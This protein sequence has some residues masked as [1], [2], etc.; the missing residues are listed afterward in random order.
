MAGR[1]RTSPRRAMNLGSAPLQPQQGDA[2]ALLCLAPTLGILAGFF[3]TYSCSFSMR[4]LWVES[5]RSGG[6]GANMVVGVCW[7]WRPWRHS[8]WHAVWQVP[9]AL[10]EAPTM[11]CCTLTTGIHP[12]VWGRKRLG[13]A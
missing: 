11:A 2:A 6:G 8:E 10:G 13:G 5:K 7:G 9:H 4:F 3:C 1:G 12:L